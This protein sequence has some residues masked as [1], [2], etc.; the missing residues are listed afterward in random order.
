VS[1]PWPRRNVRRAAVSVVDVGAMTGTELFIQGPAGWLSVPDALAG[2]GMVHQLRTPPGAPWARRSSPPN[3]KE[4]V[5]GP[6]PHMG[7]AASTKGAAHG[8][9]RGG[10]NSRRAD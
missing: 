7:T 9:G 1:L 8:W 6:E 3:E 10:S 4:H 5:G 2:A